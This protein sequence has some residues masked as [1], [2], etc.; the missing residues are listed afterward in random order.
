MTL[1]SLPTKIL[2]ENAQSVLSEGM[3]A[4]ASVSVNN[5]L[6]I[7]CQKL[8]TFDSTALSII[9]ALKRQAQK[10]AVTIQLQDVPEK[11][12]SL[13]EVYGVANIVLS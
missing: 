6:N 12:V 7:D 11:L 5:A 9:L 8:D 2:H 13:A 3:V 10:R 1:Y 4:L